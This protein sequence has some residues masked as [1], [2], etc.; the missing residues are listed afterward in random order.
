MSRT[1]GSLASFA[2]SPGLA[3]LKLSGTTAPKPGGSA[4]GIHV[5]LELAPGTARKAGLRIA[6]QPKP[7]EVA[8][9][10]G[11]VEVAGVPIPFGWEDYDGK[12]LL[13]S[14]TVADGRIEFYGN[15]RYRMSKA[16]KVD[17]V[18]PVVFF[19]EGGEATIKRAAVDGK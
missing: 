15:Q 16:L 14:V 2:S 7:I 9:S 18:G 19:A 17:A 8:W 12:A 4:K 13:W 10:A 6:A 1:P 3:N 5:A 11:Q